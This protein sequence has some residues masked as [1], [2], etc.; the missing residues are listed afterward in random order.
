MQSDNKTKIL[1][2]ILEKVNCFL[3]EPIEM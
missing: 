2:E 1:I 3:K